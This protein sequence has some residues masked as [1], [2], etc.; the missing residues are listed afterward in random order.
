M[1]IFPLIKIFLLSSLLA[2]C[3][4]KMAY[5]QVSIEETEQ[6]ISIEKAWV[7]EQTDGNIYC[8]K[9]A[10]DINKNIYGFQFLKNGDLKVRQKVGSCGTEPA[11]YETVSGSWNKTSDSTIRLE[12]SYWGGKIIQD[13]LIVSISNSALQ[14]KMIGFSN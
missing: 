14:T 6:E 13:I 5:E 12:Y 9:K 11:M 1:K 2:S 10:T 8:Y 3:K 7:G 4:H